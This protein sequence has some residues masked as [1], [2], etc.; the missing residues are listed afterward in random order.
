MPASLSCEA[1]TAG[2]FGALHRVC[3]PVWVFYYAQNHHQGL[4]LRWA[5][6]SAPWSWPR[7][8]LAGILRP[9]LTLSGSAS[10]R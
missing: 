7:S 10:V 6:D 2:G 8:L 4:W 3:Q 5:W 1:P 9:Q